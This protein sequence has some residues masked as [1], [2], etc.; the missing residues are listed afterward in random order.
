MTPCLLPNASLQ[1]PPWIERVGREGIFQSSSVGRSNEKV[2]LRRGGG[3]SPTFALVWHRSGF[4]WPAW[5]VAPLLQSVT[6]VAARRLQT[7]GQWSVLPILELCL[8]R[9]VL[10]YGCLRFSSTPHRTIVLQ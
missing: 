2:T 6:A 1:V 7:A 8:V 3:G 4:G 5:I 10:S 9:E